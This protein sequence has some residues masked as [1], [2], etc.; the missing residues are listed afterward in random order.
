MLM[1]LAL[2]QKV[3]TYTRVI[4]QEE[5]ERDTSTITW[6]GRGPYHSHSIEDVESGNAIWIDAELSED[7]L[8]LTLKGLREWMPP[9]IKVKVYYVQE[10]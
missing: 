7:K 9:M 1:K 4:K 2:D 8:A 3:K 10:D 5:V 6:K